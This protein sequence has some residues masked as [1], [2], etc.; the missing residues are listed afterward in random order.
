MKLY[1]GDSKIELKKIGDNSIDSII[2]DP[3]Y[4]IFYQ[5]NKWDKD[6]PEQDIW[7]ECY[8]CLKPGGFGA[9]FSSIKN[10]HKITQQLEDENFII[11]DILFYVFLN[12]MPKSRNI[13]LD[14]DKELGVDS[15]VIGNYDYIQG[16]SKDKKESYTS[17]KKKYKPASDIGVKYDGFGT[18]LKP[19]YEPIILIQKPISEKTIA[20]N[21]IKWSVGGL[22]FEE[23]RI[24]YDENESKV[25]HNPH[26][27]GRVAGN[28]IR[29]EPFNDGYDKFFVVQKVRKF[30][31]GI[32]HPTMKSIEL[33]EHL[34]KLLS[35]NS[36]L[37]L[38]PFMGSGSTGVACKNLNRDFIGIEL[39]QDYF[40]MSKKRLL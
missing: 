16:Y 4:G 31:D 28:I 29:T 1:N 39:N 7:K 15:E 30:K 37:I 34:V 2:T 6:L 13:G 35:T 10:L 12:G 3:P 14:I 24:P 33:M 20:K 25:G 26:P 19:C 32:K 22:N 8:R 27:K 9:V 5:N 36:Q 21:I 38:D 40:E 11:K 17:P 18:G 23:T